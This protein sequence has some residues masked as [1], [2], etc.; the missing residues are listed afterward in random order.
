ME[1]HLFVRFAVSNSP[2]MDTSGIIRLVALVLGGVS[3]TMIGS[4]P[5]AQELAALKSARTALLGMSGQVA[6]AIGAA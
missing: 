3:T 2:V 1:T 5:S 6:I 4:K